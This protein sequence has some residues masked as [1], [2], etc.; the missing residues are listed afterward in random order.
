MVSSKRVVSDKQ[1]QCSRAGSTIRFIVTEVSLQ[2]SSPGIPAAIAFAPKCS[3]WPDCGA[4]PVGFP[5][6][7]GS[8]AV[9]VDTGCP[10]FNARTSATSF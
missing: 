4:F 1:F 5:Q 3:G 10:Y 2:L 7:I 6:E 8:V 9:G